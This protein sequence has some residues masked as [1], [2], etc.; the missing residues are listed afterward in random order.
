MRSA[1]M[2][3][4]GGRSLGEVYL[5]W[6]QTL[7]MRALRIDGTPVMVKIRHRRD[8]CLPSDLAVSERE[9]EGA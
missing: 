5:A 9:E 3:A 8:F 1:L 4:G 6:E 2:D 7:A